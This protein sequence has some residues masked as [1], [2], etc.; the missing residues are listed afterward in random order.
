[1]SLLC[2]TGW[3]DECLPALFGV[4]DTACELSDG[5]SKEVD[6]SW[7]ERV[8]DPGL[9]FFQRQSHAAST[10]VLRRAELLDNLFARVGKDEVVGILDEGQAAETVPSALFAG[11]LVPCEQVCTHGCLHFPFQTVQRDIRQER[12]EHSPLWCSCVCGVESVGID[13]SGSE[14]RLDA[15]M[16]TRGGLELS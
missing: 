14:P 15:S 8:R 3:F 11:R 4:C 13:G 7:C 10:T 9:G 16:D 12:G 2:L 5:K 6:A 1:M